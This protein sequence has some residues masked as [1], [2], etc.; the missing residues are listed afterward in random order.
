MTGRLLRR[1]SYRP[2]GVHCYERAL[3]ICG[4]L[5]DRFF[6]AYA[7]LGLAELDLILGGH[8]TAQERDEQALH[9]FET[10]RIPFAETVRDALAGLPG[11]PN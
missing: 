9:L 7:L 11:R 10:L 1:L 8:T 6:Q 2:E 3:T 4:D 5:G